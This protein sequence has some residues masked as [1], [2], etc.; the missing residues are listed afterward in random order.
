MT[1]GKG[2]VNKMDSCDWTNIHY[3][4]VSLLFNQNFTCTYLAALGFM[5]YLFSQSLFTL[6]NYLTVDHGCV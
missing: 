4:R 1:F 6:H 3:L 2:N 5:R